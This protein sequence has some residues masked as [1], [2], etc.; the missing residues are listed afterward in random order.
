MRSIVLIYIMEKINTMLATIF[1]MFI[2]MAKVRYVL[3]SKGK[4]KRKRIYVCQI[5]TTKLLV[6]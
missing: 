4:L 1:I 6:K 3:V 2:P 5:D